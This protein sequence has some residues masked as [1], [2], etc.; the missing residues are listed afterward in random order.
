MLSEITL[1]SS[2]LRLFLAVVFGGLIGIERRHKRRAAGMRTHILVCMGA[3]LAMITGQ[4]IFTKFG[5]SD[6]ARLGAQVISGIGFLGVGTIIID[7]QQQV[8]GLTTAAGLWSSAC[9]GLALGIGF[10]SGACMA[11]FFIILTETLLNRLE[12]TVMSRSR[13]MEVYAEFKMYHNINELV[14]LAGGNK[15]T[16]SRL[17]IVK[18]RS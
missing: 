8:R 18:P 16:I 12:N 11:F 10:Y 17:E 2:F 4:Y 3:V 1:L 15:I 7:R 14:A 9:M 5:A 6:P 13:N